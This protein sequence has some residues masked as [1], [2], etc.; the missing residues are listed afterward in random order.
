MC[1]RDRAQVES[2]MCARVQTPNKFPCEPH[3][4]FLSTARPHALDFGSKVRDFTSANVSIAPAEFGSWAE[5][6]TEIMAE[7]KNQLK[8]QLEQELGLVTDTDAIQKLR[9]EFTAKERKLEHEVDHSIH[10]FAI[11]LDMEYNFLS[12][13]P[14]K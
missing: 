11:T 3:V 13:G 12:L 7:R 10:S 9:D 8:A 6:R 2:Q 14:Q 1:I 5:A 4:R